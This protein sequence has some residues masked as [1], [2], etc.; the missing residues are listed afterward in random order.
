MGYGT[1][2]LEEL[3][4]RSGFQLEMDTLPVRS[5]NVFHAVIIAI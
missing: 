4:P 1:L 2:I 5:P 3:G